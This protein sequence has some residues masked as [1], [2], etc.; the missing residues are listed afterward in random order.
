ME[1]MAAL[2]EIELRMAEAEFRAVQAE[3]SQE[4]D[5]M[6]VSGIMDNGIIDRIMAAS[7]RVT[8]ARRRFRQCPAA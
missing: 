1:Y 3:V 7:D 2:L 8:E 5:R 4:L 6:D